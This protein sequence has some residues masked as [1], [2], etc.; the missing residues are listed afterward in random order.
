MPRRI[1]LNSDL[2]EGFGPWT[3]GDDDAMLT[4]VTS[5]NVACGGHAG[6]TETM[7]RT[8][9][10]AAHHG[11]A[12]GAHP[13]YADRE[14]F[15]RRVIPMTL[16]EIGRLVAAQIGAL[17]A[18]AALV[19]IEVGYVK[20]HG[21]LG[22]LAARDRSVARA[23]VDAV[24]RVDDDLALLAISG[25]ALEQ[26]AREAGA[27]VFSEDFADRGYR[28]DGQLVPRDQPGA[29]IDDPVEATERLLAFL[30]T[31]SMPVVDGDPIPL[32]A[33]SVCVHGDGPGA[34]EMARRIREGL[35]DEGVELG[36]FASAEP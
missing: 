17:R 8:L 34:V 21:A 27:T 1:D 13:G 33:H 16:P 36:A 25:T 4:L 28:P 14:G 19:P 29:M 23:I 6:D 32:T 7:F 3:M 18:V 9:S 12:V 24:Q 10:T 2:G 30:A 31:G 22:N 15:G 26:V 35:I 20:P 5:A 11:V